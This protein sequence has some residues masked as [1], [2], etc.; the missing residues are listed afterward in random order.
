MAND[1]IRKLGHAF[2]NGFWG[3]LM[4]DV[5]R[6]AFSGTEKARDGVDEFT[7]TGVLIAY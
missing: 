3:E 2:G 1:Y 4:E 6:I 5:I 7:D